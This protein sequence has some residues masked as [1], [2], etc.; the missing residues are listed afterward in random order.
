MQEEVKRQM[1]RRAKDTA[2]ETVANSKLSAFQMQKMKALDAKAQKEETRQRNQ[3]Q[4]AQE[5]NRARNMKEMIRA[6]K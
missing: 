6:Q 1:N 3:E 5:E 2:N 4:R